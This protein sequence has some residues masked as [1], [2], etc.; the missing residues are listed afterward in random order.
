VGDQ[1]D[2]KEHKMLISAGDLSKITQENRIKI[3]E[4]FEE[5]NPE[6]VQ[7]IVDVLMGAAKSGEKAVALDL[8]ME[9]GL[10]R[11]LTMYL[12]DWGYRFAYNRDLE[13]NRVRLTI[14]WW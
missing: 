7:K 8:K 5:N 13:N 10:L 9:E 1:D 2:S 4:Q 3:A 6:L 11:E 12:S 14:K